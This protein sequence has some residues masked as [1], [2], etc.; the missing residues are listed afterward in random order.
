V[1][2]N[3]AVAS[4][5]LMCG[6]SLATSEAITASSERGEPFM[7]NLINGVCAFVGAL[8]AVGVLT[9]AAQGQPVPGIPTK[10]SVWVENRGVEQAVPI[11]VEGVTAPISVQVAGVPTVT[12]SS[13][14]VLPTRPVRQVWEYRTM[15]VKSDGELAATL[16]AVG[17]DG[18]ELVGTSSFGQGATLILKR[19]RGL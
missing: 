13:A 5:V 12:I 18:W 11:T 15:T 9:A 14:T 19:P 6:W 7:K 4:L 8:A 17:P 3:L 16:A 2:A 10:P 1:R